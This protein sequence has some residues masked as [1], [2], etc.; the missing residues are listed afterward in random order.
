[1]IFNFFSL[2]GIPCK[3]FQVSIYRELLNSFYESIVLNGLE[4]PLF[5]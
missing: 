1:M 5:I 2:G 3:F 4:E